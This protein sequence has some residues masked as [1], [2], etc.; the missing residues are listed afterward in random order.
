MAEVYTA[1]ATTVDEGF[2]VHTRI[3]WGPIFAG[4]AVAV[5]VG[6]FL[7]V[8]GGAIGLSAGQD[9]TLGAG[10]TIWTGIV[11]LI[12]LFLGG[13]VMTQC[14]VGESKFESVIYGVILWSLTFVGIGWLAVSGVQTGLNTM[15]G[16]VNTPQGQE[17]MRQ[18]RIPAAQ[19]PEQMQAQG[20]QMME[21]AR[22]NPAPVSWGAFGFI[23]LS[24]IASVLG[25]LVG[26]GTH[27]LFRRHTER[28][29]YPAPGAAPPPR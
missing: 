5:A 1:H 9:K 13:W 22:E 8:L 23:L 17:A 28:V 21:K 6:V 29:V 16:F 24:M 27:L 14:A 7:T 4:A 12:S 25:A 20:Q 26:S 15:I 3:R 18:E 11:C 19:N 10:F 2:P